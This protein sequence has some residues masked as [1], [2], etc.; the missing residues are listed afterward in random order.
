MKKFGRSAF[1]ICLLML[2]AGIMRADIP[3]AI[4]YKNKA[5]S[6]RESKHFNEA[7]TLF[8]KTLNEIP[9][10]LRYGSDWNYVVQNLD[11][12]LLDAI[13]AKQ[14]TSTEIISVIDTLHNLGA[15]W[16][17]FPLLSDALIV[18]SNLL[19]FEHLSNKLGKYDSN[20]KF[21]VREYFAIGHSLLSC[22][23]HSESIR[24]FTLGI[25]EAEKHKDY[26]LI[27]DDEN[28]CQWY[29]VSYSYFEL[30]QIKEG[31][32]SIEKAKDAIARDFGT[33][34]K[35]YLE[36]LSDLETNVSLYLEDNS[37]A[38]KYCEE[39]LSILRDN[40]QD[41]C[42]KYLNWSIKLLGEYKTSKQYRKAIELG[43]SIIPLLAEPQQISVVAGAL[44]SAYSDLG[45][46]DK[47]DKFYRLSIDKAPDTKTSI[48]PLC[49]Y[50]RFLYESNRKTDS[51]K[52]GK[53]VE[54]IITSI[55][56]TNSSDSIDFSFGYNTLAHIH[57]DQIPIA[58]GYMNRAEGYLSPLSPAAN[59]YHYQNKAQL[60]SNPYKQLLALQEAEK[61]CLQ[62]NNPIIS[63]MLFRDMG[64]RCHRIGDYDQALLYY[65]KATKSLKMS[66][67][68]SS[69]SVWLALD[70]NKAKT[71][72][73]IGQ[74]A[75]AAIEYESVLKRIK[76]TSGV[77]SSS[78]R[79]V[80]GNLIQALIKN[81]DLEYASIYLNE[82][83]EL[84]AQSENEFE[85]SEF[86]CLSGL[87]D[88][89]RKDFLSAEKN[90]SE[91]LR[92]IG[93]T[94]APEYLAYLEGLRDVYYQLED[95][96]F[97]PVF[98]EVLHANITN[99]IRDFYFLSES[100]RKTALFILKNLKN[101]VL[102]RTI[103]YPVIIPDALGLSLFAKGFLLRL[104]DAEFK[105]AAN[106][107]QAKALLAEMSE[108]KAKVIAAINA[109]DF[110]TQ[111]QEERLI[112]DL[113]RKFNNQF[114]E[115]DTLENTAISA[116]PIPASRT[117]Y[118]DFEEYVNDEGEKSLMAFVIANEYTISAV[119][120]SIPEDKSLESIYRRIWFPLDSLLE[121]ADCIYFSTDGIL[122]TM[123]IEFAEDED[124][125]PM[126][127]KYDMHRVF[128]LSD[129]RKS[130]GIGDRVEAIGVADHNSPNGE[131]RGLDDGYR[132][133][134]NDLAGVE[135]ELYRIA[136]SLDG[137]SEYHRA[138]ND[139]ATEAYVKSL[140]GQPIT[141]L[142]ISTHGFYRGENELTKAF[143]DTTDF[144]HNI[145]RRLL[146]G[147]RTSAS[148]LVM[149][150]GN[151]SWKAET[152]TEDEDNI[153]TSEEVETLSF[154]KL[155][156]TVLSACE[157]G[158]GELSADGVWGLQRAFRI[159]GSA[160][161][162]CSLRQVK[163]NGAADFM[164]EFYRQAAIGKSVHDA[165]YNARKELLSH[166]PANKEVWSSF[167]L[168]E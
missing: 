82:Y 145:A 84:V 50:S 165:F 40:H 115:L 79:T 51:H 147:N 14:I 12:C 117:K 143:N 65:L 77:N 98:R 90:Y 81:N 1:L 110:K 126:C 155:N 135:T 16:S 91:A 28:L 105:A 161:L 123:P 121:D 75:P 154:P 148:G 44:A 138:F 136:E 57:A 9:K 149:R 72:S 106:N 96:K 60:E 94:S 153:L 38:I 88:Y 140:S 6:A 20:Y 86:H 159:A 99:L 129:I 107:P 63:G 8:V 64:D 122:N 102:S 157:T 10:D 53:K 15:L 59:F 162:I 133:N 125:V 49:N 17:D 128:H 139:E 71:H 54:S 24:Y 151:L 116:I 23:R 83:G 11:I 124:G 36:V 32:E 25:E 22:K 55:S 103:R 26:S 132:G 95:P 158:L 134:W 66:H 61:W 113:Y 109:M 67:L 35:Q 120:L 33:S 167:L 46:K 160:S 137:I 97:I 119:R 104:N 87:L 89:A 69:S 144:D 127:E 80:L 142:H 45:I 2:V 78:Y 34:S 7:T 118:I 30:G 131:A 21:K 150:N 29:F 168:I 166:D 19:G 130:E 111:A 76:S 3:T 93:D 114:V 47:A 101:D 112:A 4:N 152:I 164:A 68:D 62:L 37:S 108:H 18:Y 92:I 141:T 48:I 39:A 56:P 156:L 163:D 42:S 13:K 43:E 5:L 27:Y 41:H 58:K 100:E 31:I 74:Y 52:V 73:L 85:R 70:N 146:M